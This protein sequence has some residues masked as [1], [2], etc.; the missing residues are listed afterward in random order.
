MADELVRVVAPVLAA[1]FAQH[2]LDRK[3]LLVHASLAIRF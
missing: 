3:D 2:D 1:A